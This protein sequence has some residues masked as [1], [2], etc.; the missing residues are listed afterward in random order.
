MV[1]WA[2][3]LGQ[4]PAYG[5]MDLLGQLPAYGKMDHPPAAS[6]PSQESGAPAASGRS[7]LGL[8]CG[9]P[10][11]RRKRGSSLRQVLCAKSNLMHWA[12]PIPGALE[13]RLD[14]LSHHTW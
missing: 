6:F 12:E 11:R 8:Q 4:L 10:S 14:L 7:S 9:R 2:C 3:L 13:S 1:K 5:K